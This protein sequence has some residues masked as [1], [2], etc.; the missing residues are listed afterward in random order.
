MTFTPSHINDPAGLA[1]II[2][3]NCVGSVIYRV[4]KLVRFDHS[5][6]CHTVFLVEN[7]AATDEG[8][9]LIFLAS[10]ESK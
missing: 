4:Y 9:S 10:S 5:F 7:C 8:S 3:P 6:T 2:S 1:G